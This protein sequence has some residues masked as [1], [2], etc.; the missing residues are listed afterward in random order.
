M[1]TRQQRT[2]P[3]KELSIGLPTING[4]YRGLDGVGSH[5]FITTWNID[6]WIGR[7]ETFAE[8]RVNR[9][10][11]ILSG[12]VES[13]ANYITRKPGEERAECPIVAR[14]C[15]DLA[16]PMVDRG[17]RVFRIQDS[18]LH[19]AMDIRLENS[20]VG[21]NVDIMV[22]NGKFSR[23]SIEVNIS[24]RNKGTSHRI[25]GITGKLR[26]RD[27]A[28]PVVA[29]QVKVRVQQWWVVFK[30]KPVRIVA[31]FTIQDSGIP[32]GVLS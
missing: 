5:R 19:V 22:T 7:F 14:C 29:A 9:H 24:L 30:V 18:T 20:E 11:R 4:R 23:R 8:N 26:F 15:G 27:N 10:A 16:G 28:V 2:S 32:V 1:Y 17:V 13:L 12:E 3:N 31:I 21:G 25:I 6:G